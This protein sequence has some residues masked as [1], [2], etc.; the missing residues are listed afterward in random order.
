M[1]FLLAVIAIIATCLIAGG[2]GVLAV[3]FGAEPEEGSTPDM[4][5]D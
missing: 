5:I 3:L 4:D 1:F 2:L